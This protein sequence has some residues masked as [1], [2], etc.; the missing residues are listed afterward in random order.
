M[1]LSLPLKPL[2]P[3]Y[4][5]RVTVEFDDNQRT[6]ERHGIL[7]HKDMPLGM[8]KQKIADALGGSVSA[9]AL[10]IA[11]IEDC[12]FRYPYMGSNNDRLPDK[13][14]VP[15]EGIFAFEVKPPQE[16][17]NVPLAVVPVVH[18]YNASP[19][20][21]P[22]LVALP[23]CPTEYETFLLFLS[24]R[25]R[26][27]VYTSTRTEAETVNVMKELVLSLQQENRSTG[28]IP[29]PEEGPVEI[30]EGSVLVL[31]WSY[32]GY[33]K[34]YQPSDAFK[35]ME[36]NSAS[37]ALG[38]QTPRPPLNIQD[39]LT[40]FTSE[41]K[42]GHDDAWYCS[43]CKASREASKKMDLW[44]LPKV[45]ILHLKRFIFLKERRD[46]IDTFV[47]FPLKGLD[48][49][50][51]V[52]GAQETP[53]V[54]DLFA[55]SNH[56]GTLGSGHYITY[57]QFKGQWY[58]FDDSRVTTMSESSVK[59]PAAYILCYIQRDAPG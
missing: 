45:L 57:A 4:V 24:R 32:S 17:T 14:G 16:L 1:T 3:E 37:M 47:D 10:H 9:S 35:A 27:Y 43:S 15:K 13:E 42:L 33:N 46:K 58:N 21:P 29:I 40:L 8:L 26:R 39:C 48:M 22:F 50:N 20:G 30:Q 56:Y 38:E 49:S 55:V 6:R 34:L 36:Y 54:Y 28:L 12:S 53:P 31:N 44:R 7:V 19:F 41:E 11:V 18:R 51:F 2:S 59:S 25:M 5:V 52:R 23:L